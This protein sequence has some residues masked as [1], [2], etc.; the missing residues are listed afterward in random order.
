ML[1]IINEFANPEALLE[2]RN[3]Q[4]RHFWQVLGITDKVDV[5]QLAQLQ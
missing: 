3:G 4:Q 1:D 5:H 2:G